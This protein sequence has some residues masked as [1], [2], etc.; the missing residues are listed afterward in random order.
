VNLLLAAIVISLPG[1]CIKSSDDDLCAAIPEAK[2]T[3]PASV[4]AGETIL[5]EAMS[6]TGARY[7][8]WTGPNNF[9]S[10]EQTPSVAG[11]QANAAGRYTVEIGFDEG[12]TRVAKTDSIVIV[13][14]SP[15]CTPAKNTGSLAGAGSMTFT[16]ISGAPTGG[17]FFLRASGSQGDLEIEF[18]GTSKPA[19]GVY[20]IEPLGGNWV[21]GDVRVRF[22]AQSS[23]WPASSGKVYVK[24]TSNKITATV[25]NVPVYNQTF[26]FSSTASASITEQ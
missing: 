12:C 5:L 16:T 2:I 19:D 7:Y 14:P 23:N 1:G 15:T 17:S 6:I 25:C 4:Q 9:V 10:T 8:Q 3:A 11:A 20:T 13:V 24:S 26:S 21:T 18:P 22:V